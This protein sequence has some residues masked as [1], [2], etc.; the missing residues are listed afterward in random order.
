MLSEQEK[1]KDAISFYSTNVP[2][3][4]YS[5]EPTIQI[6]RTYRPE[7]IWISRC[8]YSCKLKAKLLIKTNKKYIH[9]FYSSRMTLSPN[10]DT[11]SIFF[12]FCELWINIFC[13]WLEWNGIQFDWNLIP[14][15]KYSRMAHR[16]ANQNGTE[17]NGIRQ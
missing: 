1:R 5:S 15:I 14:K 9:K 4:L 17:R 6:R 12:Q 16:M 8:F 11:G 2:T 13:I 3:Y 7:E 10:I